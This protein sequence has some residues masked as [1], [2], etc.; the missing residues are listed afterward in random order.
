MHFAIL[1]AGKGSR[2]VA[3]GLTTPKPMVK[4]QGIPLIE[5][6]INVFLKN[7]AS[8]V[9][10]IINDSMKEV[11]EYVRSL[12]ISVPLNITLKSTPSSLHSFFE[13]SPFIKEK[14]FCLTT[15][16]TVFNED[17]FAEFI[18]VFEQDDKTDGL[19]A[20]TRFIDDEKP[21]YVSVDENGIITNFSNQP[22]NTAKYVSGGIYGLTYKSL[23]TLYLCM[24]DG[25]SQM[26]NFQ[27]RLLADGLSIKAFDLGKVAD[28]DHISDILAFSKKSSTFASSNRCL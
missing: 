18:R 16:D 13:L 23:Q 10:I 5:R 14:K 8:T 20:V 28:I 25:V 9:S 12:N 1:A 19:F 15:V 24:N 26:R 27:K 6:L 11:G 17:N 3:E 2:L 22:S 7:G 4:I 21:L